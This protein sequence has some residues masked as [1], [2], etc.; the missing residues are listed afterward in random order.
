MGRWGAIVFLG[1]C[2]VGLR[3]D[4]LTPDWLIQ[5]I[6][7]PKQFSGM[8][9][10]HLGLDSSLRPHMV[11][12]KDHLYHAWFDG[13][14]WRHEV[15]DAEDLTGLHASLAIAA[16]GDLHVSYAKLGGPNLR[17]AYTCGETWIRETVD[18]V[19]GSGTSLAVTSGGIPCIGYHDNANGD[20]RF[21]HRG[22]TGWIIDVVDSEGD[23]G[24]GTSLRLDAQDHPHLSYCDHPARRVKYAHDDGTG[25]AIQIADTGDDWPTGTSLAVGSDGSIHIAFLA[26]FSL[27]PDACVLK[28][29]STPGPG[30]PWQTDELGFVADEAA[31]PSIVLDQGGVPYLAYRAGGDLKLAHKDDVG[32]H[33]EALYE[34]GYGGDYPS[35]VIEGATVHAGFWELNIDAL[36]YGTTTGGSTAVELVDA[37]GSAGRGCSIAVSSTNH[38]SISYHYD[39][40]A[41]GLKYAWEDESGWHAELVDTAGMCG[42][43]TSL[44][45]DAAGR[46]HIAYDEGLQDD[47]RYARKDA[48]GWVLCTVDDAGD[49]GHWPSLALGTDGFPHISYADWTIDHSMKYAHEDGGGWHVETFDDEAMVGERSTIAVDSKG[50]P[51]VVYVPF[52]TV[53]LLKY[54]RRD[55]TAWH[56]EVIDPVYCEYASIDVDA[57]D[58][59]HVCYTTWENDAVVYARRVG[60]SWEHE[61]VEEGVFMLAAPSLR[62]DIAGFPHMSYVRGVPYRDLRY[63]YK[64]WLGWHLFTAD[65]EGAAMWETD[66]A[67][68]H[69]GLPHMSYFKPGMEDLIYVRMAQPTQLLVNW[70]LVD[71]TIRFSW[72]PLPQASAYWIYG[73]PH[74]S[75]FVPGGAPEY[76]YRL[77]VLPTT[78]TS[79]VTAWAPGDPTADWTYLIMAVSGEEEVLRSMRI[80]EYDR[81]LAIP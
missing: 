43:S 34:P 58:V 22:A 23:V 42:V 54:A 28:Y 15:V 38:P 8:S 76:Q 25:W 72:I 65:S 70:A 79:W 73:A 6:D 36:V 18:Q 13:A 11:Y 50:R 57:A 31:P 62:L 49:V 53:Q 29:A 52:A 81:E 3:A 10:R 56:V 17:Y 63:A 20:L 51:H 16:N 48:S 4:E 47:L 68:D 80:G 60:A 45:L 64:D 75:Y 27:E 12:G 40:L 74:H 77:A 19:V 46:A 41:G 55:P 21:A 2:V 66:L 33:V 32:W 7:C 5:G 44:A 39:E 59:P 26:R 71:H 67:L 30:E 24:L 14:T 78:T 1:V 37:E 61:T 35:L 69:L 9:D